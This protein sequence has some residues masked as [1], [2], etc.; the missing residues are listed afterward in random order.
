MRVLVTGGG[1]FLGRWIVKGLLARGDA[2]RVLG[3][4]PYPDLAEQGVETVQADIADREEVHR[5]CEGMDAVFH[6]A[7]LVGIWG[8]RADFF[9]INVGGTDH[10]IQGCLA[11]GVRRLVYTST[12]SVVYGK[13]PIENGNEDLPYPKRYLAWYPCTKAIAEEKVL[14]ANGERGLLTCSLR[15]HLIWGPGDTN[16]EPRLV[17]RAQQGRIRQVGDG[18]NRISMVR[19]ERAADAHIRMADRLVAGS[20]V[21]GRA[22]FLVDSPPVNCWDFVNGMLEKHGV[23]QM[24]KRMSLKKAYALGW[25][26]EL[27]YGLLGIRS[28]PPMTRFLALQLGTSHWFDGSRLAEALDWSPEE[29]V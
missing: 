24:S 19:V 8:R 5:A 3:R 11:H 7:A 25:V 29:E 12:P 13:S 10:V 17:A 21:P 1:G 6:T 4:R 15:P 9:R 2:V 23:P 14:K 26:F 16:L 28:E 27:L 22:Y 18:T 20:P